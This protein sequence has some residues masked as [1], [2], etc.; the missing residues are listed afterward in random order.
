[1]TNLALVLHFYQP[2]TQSLNLTEEI[3]R[4]CYLP[5]CDLL[6]EKQ[7]ARLTLN[8]S[9]S[10]LLQTQ[11]IQGHELSL[12]FRRLAESGKIDFLTSPIYHPLSPLTPSE[13]LER[14]FVENEKVLENFCGIKNFVG[15]FPPELAID[16]KTYDDFKKLSNFVMLDETSTNPHFEMGKIN[17]SKVLANCRTLTELIRSYPTELYADK[18]ANFVKSQVDDNQA[19]LIC[20][21]DAEVFGHHYRERINFLRDLFDQKQFE[22]VKLSEVINSST[23]T[24]SSITPSTWQTTTEDIKNN[25]PYPFWNNP[26]NKLQQKYYQLAQRA[27]DVL[28][29]TKTDEVPS[30]MLHSAE[31]HFDQGVSSCHPYWLSNL[32]WWHPDLAEKGAQQLIKSIRTVPTNPMVKQTAEKFYHELLMELWRHHWSGEVEKKYVEHDQKRLK[33]LSTL[34]K[35]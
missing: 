33:F 28:S 4:S 20:V 15:I 31:M 11:A 26:S 5:L 12:K 23:Q 7:N 13:V 35:I 1:M 17:S 30:H 10:L 3:L 18:F 2:P 27:W 8:I 32:P 34:P 22:F 6:L 29:E 14:Q 24:P 25:D 21:T 9:G 19:P 16:Q